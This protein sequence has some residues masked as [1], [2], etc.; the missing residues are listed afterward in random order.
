MAAFKNYSYRNKAD[1]IDGLNG[2]II[3]S[4]DLSGGLDLDGLTLIINVGGAGDRTVTFS[5]AKSRVWTAQEIYDQ[6]YAAHADLQGVVSLEVKSVR[7]D[8]VAGAQTYLKFVDNV[9]AAAVTIR[10]TGTANSLFG[11]PTGT[12]PANDLVGVP[13]TLSEVAKMHPRKDSQ[14]IWD[15]VV[16]K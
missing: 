3:S 10:S 7:P 11:F 6:I 13:I 8:L 4:V 2:A 5:P 15:V 16:Y 9:A 14:G 1:M 12:S